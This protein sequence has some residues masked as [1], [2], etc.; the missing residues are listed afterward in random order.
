MAKPIKLREFLAAVTKADGRIEVFNE[1]GK[2][3]HLMLCRQGENGKVSFPIPTS[4]GEVAVPYQNKVIALFE[5]PP[6]IFQK[7]GKKSGR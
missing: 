3:S 7:R 6:N 4:S 5:L 1:R 2:G